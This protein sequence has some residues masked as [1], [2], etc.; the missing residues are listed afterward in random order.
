MKYKF[1]P[2]RELFYFK[3]KNLEFYLQLYKDRTTPV[4]EIENQSSNELLGIIS[5]RPGW[6]KFVFSPYGSYVF[7]VAAL[8]AVNECINK[9]QQDFKTGIYKELDGY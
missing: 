5:Y 4:I 3:S 7:D 6:R 1:I 8:T 9:V 2:I